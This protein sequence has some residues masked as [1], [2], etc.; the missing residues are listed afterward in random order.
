[1]GDIVGEWIVYLTAWSIPIFA[2]EAPNTLMAMYVA[3]LVLA[4]TFGIV[5]QY[6]SIVPTR[7]DVGQP[8]GD[9]DGDQGRH[10]LD[11]RLPGRPV[12]LHGALPPRVLEATVERRESDL[13]VHDANRDDRR[14]LHR[15]AGQYL[16]DPE[17]LEGEDVA[18]AAAG[19][20]APGRRGGGASL[21]GSRP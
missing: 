4:W 18:G 3:D 14:L 15:V 19:R 1:M 13:L 20:A 21:T 9:L 11:R 6:F 8:A 2:A 12:R 16:A 17:A 10:A 5:F 7:E